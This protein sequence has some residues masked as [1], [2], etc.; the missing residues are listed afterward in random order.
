[1]I[2]ILILIVLIWILS[3]VLKRFIASLTDN[4]TK[5]NQSSSEKIVACSQCGLHIPESETHVIDDNVC[6]NNQDCQS[7]SQN[8]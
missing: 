4:K 7:K 5:T 8:K 6:C 3:I 2:R 1:M